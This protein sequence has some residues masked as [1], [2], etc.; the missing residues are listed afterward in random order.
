MPQNTVV[1]STLSMHKQ[2]AKSNYT[3]SV[4]AGVWCDLTFEIKDAPRL[5]AE[6]AKYFSLTL[7]KWCLKSGIDCWRVSANRILQRYLRL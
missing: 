1:E 5:A 4:L 3:S 2:F 6:D 7:E